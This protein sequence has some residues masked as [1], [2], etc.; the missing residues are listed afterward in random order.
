MCTPGNAGFI[1]K[2]MS[3]FDDRKVKG[4][5]YNPEKSRA[6]LAEAGFADGKGLPEITLTTVSSYRDLIEYI[7]RELNQIGIKTRVEV[8]EGASL[9]E[10]IAKNGVNFFRAS[11]NADYPDGENYLS[12][13]YSKNRA[14][15]GPN[16]TVFSNKQ[17]DVLYNQSYLVK[18]DTARYA[19]YQQMDN[20]MMQQSPVVVLY[21]DNLVNLYQNNISG[22]RVNGMNLLTLKY[23]RKR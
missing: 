13:F 7:Q 1:P 9:R 10:L 21:Y 15:I 6:L 12:V 11:W 20:L 16:Y 22:Y 3:G 19:L 23:V 4:Y 17:F 5:N 14:P 8:M 2:G 18:S